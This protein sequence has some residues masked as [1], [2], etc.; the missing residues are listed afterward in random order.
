MTYTPGRAL[1]ELMREADV[2]ASGIP[3]EFFA[4]WDGAAP[5][6]RELLAAAGRAELA[7]YIKAN[8]S[9]PVDWRALVTEAVKP[10]AEFDAARLEIARLN[11]LLAEAG[12]E[13][14]ALLAENGLLERALRIAA[15]EA[16]ME[17]AD[18]DAARDRWLREARLQEAMFPTEAKAAEDGQ[19]PEDQP[20]PKPGAGPSMHDLV[21][22]DIRERW[23]SGMLG[24]AP[25]APSIDAVTASLQERKRLG[26]ER[27][28][29]PL[30]AGN[31]RDALRDLREEIEDAVVYC[32]QVIEE[33]GPHWERRANFAI[34]YDSLIAMLFRVRE[35]REPVSGS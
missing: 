8:G 3:A 4:T 21:C 15:H 5:E 33:R 20:L 28:G 19:R 35:A 6:V 17:T 2:K 32:R 11:M 9:D 18:A 30:R 12:S 16:E 14:S 24:R 13:T 29:E 7:A 27:Y 31:G 34:M 26:L 10:A 1:F 22:D 25:V 23:A